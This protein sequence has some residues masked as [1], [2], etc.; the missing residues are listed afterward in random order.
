MLLYRGPQLMLETGYHGD[1]PTLVNC[2]DAF[3]TIVYPFQK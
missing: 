2:V 1:L 3:V